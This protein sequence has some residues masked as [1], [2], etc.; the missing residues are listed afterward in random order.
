MLLGN[1]NVLIY[2]YHFNFIYLF[3]YNHCVGA[4]LE[5][6]KAAWMFLV[7]EVVEVCDTVIGLYSTSTHRLH[8]NA[9]KNVAV[10]TTFKM[11]TSSLAL[12]KLEWE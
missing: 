6:G 1:T 11:A 2:F 5:R 7:S 8:H 3:F 10:I 12:R 4:E 9:A